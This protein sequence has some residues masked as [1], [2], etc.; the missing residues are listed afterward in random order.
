[1]NGKELRGL[2]ILGYI[3][4]RPCSRIAGKPKMCKYFLDHPAHRRSLVKSFILLFRLSSVCVRTAK[5]LTRLREC[6]DWSGPSLFVYGIYVS[7]LFSCRSTDVFLHFRKVNI[8]I[9]INFYLSLG[10]FSRQQ[11]DYTFPYFP[12]KLGSCISCKLSL[13]ETI[14]M[15][16]QNIFPGKTK[17]NIFKCHLLNSLTQH[18]KRL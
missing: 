17:K 6:A 2:T 1:M 18:T 15:K 5:A 7:T 8:K 16:C 11:I 14:C 13:K 9:L 3:R 10:R 4:Y 12:Q